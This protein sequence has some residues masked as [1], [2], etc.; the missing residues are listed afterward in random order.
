MT[1]KDQIKDLEIQASN[2]KQ[3]M[4]KLNRAAYGLTFEEVIRLLGR[5]D[6]DPE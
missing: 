2:T 4:D 6:N 5:R 3:L 1:E